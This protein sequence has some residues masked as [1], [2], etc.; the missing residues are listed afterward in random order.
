MSATPVLSTWLV[1]RVALALLAL[2]LAAAPGM[3]T[4]IERVVSPG[5]IVAWLVR[6]PAVPMIAVDFAFAGGSAQD[7]AEKAG[8]ASLVAALLDEGAG[9][10]DSKAFHTRL[11]RKAIE[12]GFQAD[13]DALRGALRTLTGNSEEAFDDLRLALTAPRFDPTDVEIIRSQ[14]ISSLRRATTSPSEMASI[15]WWQTAFADH[16]YGHPVNGTLE[17]VPTVGIDDL[18]AYTRR[19]LARDNLK[20][21]VVGDIDAEA[22]KAMLDRVFGGLP[23]HA[24][25]AAV[26]DVSPRGLGRRIVTGLDVPQT[27]IMFGGLGIARQDPDFMA[28]YIV[29]HIL[30]GGSFSSRLYQEVREKRGLAYSVHDSLTW[31]SHAPLFIGGTATRS[32]RTTETLDIVQKEISRLADDGPTADELAKAKSFLIGSFPLNLDTSSKIAALLVQLQIDNL[33][34]DYFTQ[35]PQMIGAVTLDDARRVSK[36][37]LGGGLLVTVVG[38]PDGLMSTSAE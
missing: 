4:T 30:G 19:V 37:L 8:T 11:E 5:G 28:A 2:P 7:P 33:G 17:S 13:R 38:R 10:F 12:L 32:E 6:E 27:V 21:A 24:E 31:L 3:A 22:V 9:D 23:A 26:A 25:L 15:R 20:V 34:I 35:R 29:N 36:Q 14:I 16:P 18:K 1:R